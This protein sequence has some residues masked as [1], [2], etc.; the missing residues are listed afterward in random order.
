M[1]LLSGGIAHAGNQFLVTVANGVGNGIYDL[2]ETAK[3]PTAHS[4][5]VPPRS[6]P[7]ARLAAALIL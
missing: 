5:R 4:S 3:P 7:T 1:L 6:T 2:T